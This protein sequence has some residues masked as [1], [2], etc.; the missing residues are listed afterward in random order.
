VRGNGKLNKCRNLGGEILQE[1]KYSADYDDPLLAELYDQSET[2]TD[3]V[4]LIRKLIGNSKPLKVLEVFS[5]TG[6]ILIPLAED[7]HEL[8]GLE[9]AEA[10][11]ARA[12][13]KIAKLEGVATR[14]RLNT[15]DVVEGKW[16]QGFDLVIIGGNALYELP[17][18]EMQKRCIRFARQA[19]VRGGRVFID[20]NDYKGNWGEGPFGSK[21]M[22]FEGYGQDGSFGRW[23]MDGLRFDAEEQALYMKRTWYKRSLDGTEKTSEY[24]ARKHPVSAQEIKGWLK[25]YGF[26][27]L[28]LFGDRQG[29]PYTTRSDRAIFWARKT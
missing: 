12:A 26:E 17:D 11:N 27:I 13:E 29:N 6:R 1:Y 18:P 20:N 10:M 19:L 28:D 4:E 23:C 22:I 24:I 5:G 21:R 15:Q 7:G 14:V 25:K 9:I 16:G 2:C 3:D 8:T